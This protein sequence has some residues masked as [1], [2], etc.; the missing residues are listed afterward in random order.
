MASIARSLL[1]SFSRNPRLARF[2]Y[3]HGNRL[4]IHRFIAGTTLDECVA[5]LRRLNERGFHANT[6]LL[7]EA[8]EDPAAAEKVKEAYAEILERLSREKLRC[9]V[10]LKLSHLGLGISEDVAF[11]HMVELLTLARDLSRRE[12]AVLPPA[13]HFIRM[14]MEESYYVD[15]T[16]SIY[17]RL[18]EK[19]FENV[20]I[21]LQAYLHRSPKD[22]KD[23]L[24][25]QPNV[26]IVKGAYME[27]ASVA[28]QDRKT[29]DEKYLELVQ[30]GLRNGC[31]VAA[32]THDDRLIQ[33]IQEWTENE[34]IGRD[35][36]E[37]QMLYGIR[38]SLQEG[39]LTQGY[40]VLVATPF[41]KDW[42]PYF[43]RRLAERPANVSLVWRS[44][45]GRG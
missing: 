40:K 34:G 14:D 43:M 10:A 7:G 31:Y 1:L 20:G 5:V 19:G 38:P 36:F 37:F 45:I 12:G 15:A 18:R 4:G 32:A 33:K 23:L 16:L 3:R 22:L 42:Y 6:T 13:G 17:R 30:M 39:V 27:P 26:R 41:G 29:I 2:A 9:N 24:P 25:F 28:Y 44:W 8:V 11:G 35:R 21:V